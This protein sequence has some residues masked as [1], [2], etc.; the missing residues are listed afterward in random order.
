MKDRIVNVDRSESLLHGLSLLSQKE[1][2]GIDQALTV[3]R[4]EWTGKIIITGRPQQGR[5]AAGE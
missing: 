3:A 2:V 5:L 4:G 1:G